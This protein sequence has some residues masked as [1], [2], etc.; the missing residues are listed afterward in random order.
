VKDAGI[1]INISGKRDRSLFNSN[2]DDF[3]M[4]GLRINADSTHPVV[5]DRF[6]MLVRDYR[7]YSA[8]SSAAYIFDSIH[9][10][11][12]KI[13][14]SN[15]TVATQLDRQ[16]NHNYRDFRIPYFELTGLDW[17]ELVFEQNVRAREAQLFNPVI[18]YVAAGRGK[19][20]KKKT[21]L[22][23]ALESIG[24]L[25]SLDKVN[26]VNGQINMKLGPTASFDLQNANLTLFSNQLLQSR[27][28]EGLRRAVD[29][30]SFSNGLL[31]LKNVTAQLQNV[32]S[33]PA[34]LIQADRINLNS[35]DNKIK[36]FLTAVVIDNML[37]DDLDE[38]IVVDGIRWRSGALAIKTGEV[39]GKGN[40]AGSIEIRNVAGANTRLDFSNGKMAIATLLTSLKLASLVKEG[41]APARTAGLQLS[42]QNLSFVNEG[43]AL[44]LGGYQISG[45]AP[46]SLTGVDFQQNKG[47]D[48]LSFRAPRV[49]FTAD[50]NG[51]LANRMEIADIHAHKPDIRMVKWNEAAKGKEVGNMSLRIDRVRASEPVIN[52]TLHKKDSMSAISFPRSPNS[53]IVASDL[54]I[55]SAGVQLGALSAKT[56]AVTFLKPS[57]EIVGVKDGTVDMQF[58]A[59]R[60][61][62]GG[63]PS[64]SGLINNL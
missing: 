36:G 21:N 39:A 37:L 20:T 30:L 25:V 43:T 15:F 5:V 18:N 12:N 23:S 61:N 11:N 2:K 26:I 24:D 10:L 64:W 48:S 34:N 55:N 27:N 47:A 60:L 6:D 29:R 17:Y 4:R 9:F 63:T 45:A 56:T 62:R 44:K 58:S 52:I 35:P 33:T 1:H 31:R 28:G 42:G 8:D 53:N 3:E 40:G 13:V 22:F 51:L 41:K 19:P 14:L 46:S 7:L 57:G 59:L 49:D 38:T 54:V 16:Q 32:R 50:V